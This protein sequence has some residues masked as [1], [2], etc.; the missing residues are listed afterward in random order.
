MLRHTTEITA[1]AELPGMPHPVALVV[2]ERRGQRDGDFTD[3][4]VFIDLDGDGKLSRHEYL[5]PNAVLV[6]PE[7]MAWHIRVKP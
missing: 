7:G 4:G 2:S 6:S 5:A 1:V 3:D